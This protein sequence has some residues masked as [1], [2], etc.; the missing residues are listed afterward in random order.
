MTALAS[1]K[2]KHWTPKGDSYGIIQVPGAYVGGLKG[3]EHSAKPIT[4]ARGYSD[5]WLAEHESADN[6]DAPLFHGIRPQDDPSEHLYP[7]TIYQQLKRIARR[8]DEC[9]CGEHLTAH[10]QA[11]VRAWPASESAFVPTGRSSR[12]T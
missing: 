1:L 6:P 9:R 11:R 3:A 10:A 5:N 12:R 2:I 8:T 4:F 7:H